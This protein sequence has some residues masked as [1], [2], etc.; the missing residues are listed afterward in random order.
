MS[1]QKLLLE[2][3]QTLTNFEKTFDETGGKR[4]RWEKDEAMGNS[5]FRWTGTKVRYAH[6][7][8]RSLQMNLDK[9][10]SVWAKTHGSKCN[11]IESKQRELWVAQIKRNTRSGTSYL[12]SQG[13]STLK[14][15]KPQMYK[16]SILSPNQLSV[17]ATPFSTA[18]DFSIYRRPYDPTEHRDAVAD[19]RRRGKQLPKRPSSRD[20]EWSQSSSAFGHSY[21]SPSLFESYTPKRRA[22]EVP[23]VLSRESL[24]EGRRYSAR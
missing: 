12:D 20:S 21:S 9:N 8:N 23:K 17:V 24:L 3:S 19:N 14:I 6:V 1:Y 5:K 7:V 15:I 13:N 4:L 16:Q 18:S 2:Y 11:E 10:V 22:S